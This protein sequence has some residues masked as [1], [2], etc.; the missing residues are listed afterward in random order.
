MYQG[1]NLCLKVMNQ[2]EKAGKSE[3]LGPSP[4]STQEHRFEGYSAS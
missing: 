2:Q 4:N 3:K 1:K